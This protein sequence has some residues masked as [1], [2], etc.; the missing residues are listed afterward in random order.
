MKKLFLAA[1]LAVGVMGFTPRAH[2]QIV[3]AP[4]P[5]FAPAP[6]FV[7][8]PVYAPPPVFIAPAPVFVP[9]V[10]YSFSNYATP[11]AVGGT[12]TV[13]TPFGGYTTRFG[14]PA[15]F[16]PYRGGV[17]YGIWNRPGGF[18]FP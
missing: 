6:V 16:N 1:V 2:A 15:P 4:G 14:G 5:V 7:P 17:N 11:F 18:I 3:I 13:V 12:R 10:T 9:P 8:V